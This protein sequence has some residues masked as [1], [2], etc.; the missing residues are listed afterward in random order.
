MFNTTPIIHPALDKW[1]PLLFIMMTTSSL[2]L[3]DLVSHL[4]PETDWK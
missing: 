3:S 2:V 4:T 1:Q